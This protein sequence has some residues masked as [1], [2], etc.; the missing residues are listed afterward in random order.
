MKTF[1][2]FFLLTLIVG[3]PEPSQARKYSRKS[4][5]K[6]VIS[7][8]FSS[9]ILVT[10][11]EGFYNYISILVQLHCISQDCFRCSLLR[12]KSKGYESFQQKLVSS[13]RAKVCRTWLMSAMSWSAGTV[14]VKLEEAGSIRGKSEII[15]LG[16][17]R[18]LMNSSWARRSSIF[19]SE[20][21]AARLRTK[22]TMESKSFSSLSWLFTA[23]LATISDNSKASSTLSLVNKNWNKIVIFEKQFHLICS[24]VWLFTSIWIC[25]ETGFKR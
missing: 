25:T 11:K 5:R 1:S 7:L 23:R 4:V 14:L 3:N 20:I 22:L 2:S 18:P 13:L 17:T 6:L 19:F 16:S 9:S 12:W 15:S 24:K 8:D 21:N 10:Y